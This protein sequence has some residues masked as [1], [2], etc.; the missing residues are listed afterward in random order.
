MPSHERGLTSPALF[1][2]AFSGGTPANQRVVNA[3]D[4]TN[5]ENPEP[6]A[7]DKGV[8]HRKDSIS[9]DVMPQ[10]KPRSGISGGQ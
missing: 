3:D 5:R 8:V 2:G 7:V 6:H 10:M 1:A 9:G 4:R